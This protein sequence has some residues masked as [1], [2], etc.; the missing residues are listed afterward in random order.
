MTNYLLQKYHSVIDTIGEQKVQELY[1][2]LGPERISMATLQ[3]I[4]AREKISNALNERK[5]VSHVAT[6]NKV[7]R[8]TIYRQMKGK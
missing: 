2:L 6:E 5:K 1:Q 8:M 7:S 3:R 4:I